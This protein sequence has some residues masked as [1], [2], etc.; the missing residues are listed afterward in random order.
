MF[1]VAGVI[2]DNDPLAVG[3]IIFNVDV[4]LI[5]IDRM[6]RSILRNAAEHVGRRL[7]QTVCVAR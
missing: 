3:L 2:G 4:D 1:D 5:G 6:N 7:Q